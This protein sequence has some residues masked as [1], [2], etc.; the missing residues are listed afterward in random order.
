MILGSYIDFAWIP[1]VIAITSQ[2][3]KSDISVYQ[4]YR[5]VYIQ[6]VHAP[7]YSY[8]DKFVPHINDFQVE[9]HVLYI[10]FVMACIKPDQ[11]TKYN[12]TVKY[13]ICI[14]VNRNLAKMCHPQKYSKS[15]KNTINPMKGII[16]SAKAFK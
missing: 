15:V 16:E 5:T 2:F 11:Y 7:K 4:F 13:Y 1:T 8:A 12:C 6:I 10:F 9:M 14:F 3:P